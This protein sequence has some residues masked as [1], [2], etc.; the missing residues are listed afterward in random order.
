MT[1]PARRCIVFDLDGTLVDTSLDIT[2]S[3]NRTR[4]GAGLGPLSAEAVLAHVGR[5]AT[6]LL[7]D[8]VGGPLGLDEA[9]PRFAALKAAYL[10]DYRA[11]QCDQARLYPGTV[12]TLSR[13]AG[14]HALY[15]LSNKPQ[16]HVTAMVETLGLAPLL[17]QAWGGGTF[18]GLKPDPA[19]VLAALGDSRL[20]AAHGLMVGDLV[21]DLRTGRA[22]GVGTVFATWGYGRVVPDDPAPDHV[23]AS[24]AELVPLVDGL[25]V[26]CRR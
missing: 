14:N 13:L 18:A 1:A 17:R 23:I 6:R 9:S 24:A 12:A 19:G 16:A 5:G 11:H 3:V 25:R 10:A 7:L 15:V 2:A 20:P 8:T 21:I 26:E 22:A 4:A